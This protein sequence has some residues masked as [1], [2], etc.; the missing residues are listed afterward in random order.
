M[1]ILFPLVAF[2]ASLVGTYRSLGW[3]FASVV[4]TGYFSGV[5]RA[6][7][8]GIYSTFMFDF[9]VL[10][11]YAG[12]FMGHASESRDLWERP[13]GVWTLALIAW[14]V[15][16][17][18]LPMNDYLVQLVALRATVF[19]LP[20]L[21]VAT[22]L[23][24]ADFAMLARALAV[25]NLCALAVGIYL[26]I[27]GVEALYPRS[28]ITQIMYSSGDVGGG[29]HRIPSTFLNAHAYGGTML[30]TLSLLL[31]RVFGKNVAMP[32]RILAVL[33][34][35]AA[36]AGILM[37]AARLPVVVFGVA[38]MIAWLCTRFN[39]VVGVVAAGLVLAG[40]VFAL[41]NERFQRSFS[42]EDTELVSDRIRISA[43]E[44][45][46]DLAGQYPIG[47]GMGSS[48]G[49]AIPYFLADRAPIAIGMENEYCRILIDQG[50]I[51]LGLW[52]GFIFWLFGR[53][54]RARLESPW[55]IC[56][57]LAYSLSLTTWITGFIGAGM[58]ASIPGSVMMLAQ[59]GLLARI[60]EQPVDQE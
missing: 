7:F 31:D 46:F 34:T 2:V 59:M 10:G 47:A 24:A 22:R 5:I 55:G 30:W 37:C 11:L 20:V 40:F 13:S 60:R 50:W 54:P 9:A 48:I 51:G 49:T 4:A 43:N 15:C 25:L 3:G 8:I 39:P 38:T 12:F 44:G 36:I 45:F 42:L 17:T 33:G 21:L 14:P 26:Y 16:L 27:F 41:S 19:F 18:L 53:R 23:T 52:G 29:F 35:A 6:N 1:D 32:D 28:A 58:L 57:I 56:V